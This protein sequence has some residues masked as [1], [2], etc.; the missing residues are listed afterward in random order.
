MNK[1]NFVKPEIEIV[2]FPT[3]DIVTTSGI[4]LDWDILSLDPLGLDD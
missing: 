1:E 3:E 2:E 4:D